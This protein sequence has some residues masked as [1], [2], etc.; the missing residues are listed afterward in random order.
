MATTDA[1]VNT[2]VLTK[3]YLLDL[4]LNIASNLIYALV[5]FIAGIIVAKIIRYLIKKVMIKAKVEPILTNFIARI[6][7]YTIIV[8]AL[9]AALS[10]LGVPTASMIGVFTASVFAIAFAL[11]NSLNHFASGMI[12]AA[13]RP[14]HI[15]DFIDINKNASGTVQRITLFFTEIMTTENQ[16]VTIPNGNVLSSVITNF[17]TED[18]RRTDLIIGIGY[19]DDI[20]KAKSILST[21]LNHTEQVL[22]APEPIIV[23]NALSTSSVDLLLRYWTMRTDT[24]ATKWQLLETAKN[25]L[26]EHN[27]N[28]PYPQTD[29]HLYRHKENS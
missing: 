14:F 12:L 11:R 26:D 23:V 19:D 1:T 6:L 24:I 18:K 22:N 15:G 17:S 8:L 28:I 2:T 25:L 21:L 10:K 4:G 3:E 7:F 5:I 13:T 29:V 27:I 20:E 16:K 9:I